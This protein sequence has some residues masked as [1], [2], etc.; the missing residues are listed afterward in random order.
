[1]GDGV[2]RGA[3]RTVRRGIAVA[4]LLAVPGSQVLTAGSDS[5]AVTIRVHDYVDLS[6]E[7]IARAQRRVAAIFGAVGVQARWLHT[8]RPL[9][10]G[11]DPASPYE[12][13][14]LSVIVLSPEMARHRK[15]GSDVVGTAVV[16]PDESGRIAYVLFDRVAQVARASLADPM[17]VMGMVMAHEL[18]HLI[19]PHG[20]HSHIGLMRPNWTIEELRTASGIQF[21]FTARQGEVIRRRLEREPAVSFANATR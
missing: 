2:S 6:R 1:M 18:G 3:I 20:A 19:L 14:E 16:T 7:S 15:V 13:K 10:A 21:Q 17:E 9:R 8:V 12:Q 11:I 5:P 4:V